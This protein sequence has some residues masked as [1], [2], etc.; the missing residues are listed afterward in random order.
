MKRQK[1]SCLGNWKFWLGSSIIF[2]VIT[3]VAFTVPA[4]FKFMESAWGAGDFITFVGTIVLGAVATIQT[5]QANDV[6]S[7]LIDLQTEE[8]IPKLR[9]IDFFGISRFSTSLFNTVSEVGCVEM[10]TLDGELLVGYSLALHDLPIIKKEPFNRAYELHFK[11]LSET[12]ISKIHFK[13]ITFSFIDGGEK[14]FDLNDSLEIALFDGDEF[15]LFVFLMSD[16]D[17][18]TEESPSH[19]YVKARRITI[20][21][22][23]ESLKHTKHLETIIIN[24]HLTKSNREEHLLGSPS[25][26]IEEISD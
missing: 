4:P 24:K 13:S 11:Y 16:N 14:V 25:I 6:N 2:L 15:P 12:V 26:I 3:H 18:L 17:F 19:K 23:M 7:K 9:I 22:E 8:Y 21:L 1:Y 5:K 10:T 20:L